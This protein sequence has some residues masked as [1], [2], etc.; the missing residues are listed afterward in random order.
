MAWGCAVR[1]KLRQLDARIVTPNLKEARHG[2]HKSIGTFAKTAPGL[3][4][5]Y[6]IRNRLTDIED[7]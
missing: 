5:S 4:A 2:T 3:M 6:I 7:V 1:D